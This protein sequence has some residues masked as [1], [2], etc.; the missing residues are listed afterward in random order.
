MNCRPYSLW[1]SKLAAFIYFCFVWRLAQSC[2]THYIHYICVCVCAR[3][4]HTDSGLPVR[5]ARFGLFRGQKNKFGLFLNWLASNFIKIYLA[6]CLFK[7]IEVYRVKSKISPF[8][9]NWHFIPEVSI[10]GTWFAASLHFARH[11]VL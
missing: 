7:S 5:V 1:S 2:A 6:V 10:S 3:N 11:F 8:L 9:K 4:T